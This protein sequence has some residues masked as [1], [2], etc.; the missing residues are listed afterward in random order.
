MII[1]KNI[2]PYL[3]I[4]QAPI[5]EALKKIDFNEE[6]LVVCID[7]SGLLLGI[8]TDGDFRRQIIWNKDINIDSP[9]SAIINSNITKAKIT[10]S[11]VRIA[12]KLNKKVSFI[13]LTDNEGRCV[14]IA[15]KRKSQFTIDEHKI[16]PGHPC[17]VIAEIGNNHNG[18][19]E[20]AYK[21]SDKAVEAD[22]F[23]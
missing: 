20:L 16:G 5:R 21:L 23:C 18:N 7:N 6:G 13:P 3:V 4:D 15:R 14:G 9:I 11:N 10:D 8:M 17:Y 12:A 19:I 2:G 22:V 1:D